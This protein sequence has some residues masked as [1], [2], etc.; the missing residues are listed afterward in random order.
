MTAAQLRD[1]LEE[2]QSTRTLYRDLEV[3][4][5]AGFPLTN[6][7]GQWR[8]LEGS[9]GAWAIPVSPTE[10]VALMLTEDLLA[11]VEGSW[12]AQPLTELR[13]RLSASLTPIGRRYCAELRK[14]NI[15]TLFGSG[16]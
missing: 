1:A 9:E 11:P 8:L 7:D 6:E 14:A 3:L 15:A 12:L 4:Q 16:H 13:A 5:Q 10:V 2:K